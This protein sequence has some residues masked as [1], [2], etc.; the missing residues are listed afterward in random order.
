MAGV[1]DITAAGVAALLLWQGGAALGGT[2]EPGL[3]QALAK[4]PAARQRVIVRLQERPDPK[5]VAASLA[6]RSRLQM[7]GAL[8]AAL[9]AKA[10][11]AGAGLRA[12]LKEREAA[13]ALTGVRELWLAGAF[14][15]TA[16]PA[17]IRALAARSEVAEVA[18]DRVV[19]LQAPAAKAATAPAGWNLDQ[20]GAPVLW[21]LGY[22]GQGVVVA[23]LDSGV[24]LN[25]PALAGKW[26]GGSNSWFDAVSTPPSTLPFDDQG[27]GTHTM[28]VM[29]AGDTA[30]N[31]IGLAPGAT[32]IAAK[33]FDSQGNGSLSGIHAA[34]QW[35]LDPGGSG[36]GADAPRVV[37]CSWSIAG[38]GVY[39]GE[40]APDIAALEAA[41]IAVVAAGGNAGPY[42]GT[43]ES[44]AN[45]PGA[46]SVGATDQGD[47]VT[48]ISSRGPSAYDG[49]VFPA[50]T[51]PGEAIRTTDLTGGGVYP[52]SY[53]LADGT[54][55]AAP[56]VAGALALL[57]GIDPALTAAE[58]TGALQ[59]AAHDLGASGPDNSYGAGRLDVIRAADKLGLLPP[60]TPEGDVDGD[61]RVSA[62]DALLI[63]RAA[64]GLAPQTATL[65]YNGDVAPLAG[66][67]PS[68]DGNL[69]LSDALLVLKKAVG[70]ASF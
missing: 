38:P 63:L 26:R 45:N 8:L 70:L 11:A 3:A 9:R 1:R 55:L 29:V 30:G 28:G 15:V 32:W 24:D 60:H 6:G 21:Q 67:A 68:P 19:A 54:S 18:A 36:S 25:H 2:I 50:L 57:F 47:L 42:Q 40:F 41:G 66:G 4:E 44:P 43:S 5:A 69:D 31:R 52:D 58:A 49:G 33:I 27:H 17:A 22:T 13:G 65:L 12:H 56:H 39:D 46:L 37:N 62:A 7:R 61:G 34:F 51:A 10:Q 14:S 23:N 35:L 53:L 64:V 20:V 48:A 59:A 16:E